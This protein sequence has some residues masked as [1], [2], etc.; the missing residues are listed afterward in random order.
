M[1]AQEVAQALREIAQLLQLKGENSFKI[2]AYDTAAE[3]FEAL[4]PDPSAPGGLLERVKAGTLGELASVGKAIDQKVSELVTTGSLG[5]L[6]KLRA[7]FPPGVLDLVRVP[8]VGPKK[9]LALIEQLD[10]GSLTDLKAACESGKVRVLKGF[11]PKSELTILEGVN[12]LQERTA[13]R[14]IHL[15][16]PVAERLLARVRA[17]PGVRAAAVAGSIRRFA[18]TTGDIDLV[19]ELEPDALPSS[20]MDALLAGPEIGGIIGRG[21]TKLSL[22]LS[23]PSGLQV[24][25][26]VLGAGTFA[27]ALHHFTGSKGHHVRLRGIARARG[28]TLSEYGLLEMSSGKPLAVADEAALYAQL[29]LPF[30]TPELREDRGEI[31]AGLANTL[32]ELLEEAQIQ[33]LIHCHTTWSDGTHSIEEVAREAARLGKRYLSITDH[34]YAGGEKG[35]TLDRLRAQADEIAAVQ[36]RTPELRILRGVEV[37]VLED[38]S[39]ALPDA[40]LESLEL[41]IASVHQR[42]GLD[43]EAQTSRIARA[44]SHPLVDIWGHPTGRILG[45]REEMPASFEKLLAK[46]AET[47]VAVECNGT[48]RRLDLSSDWLRRARVH[49]CQIAVSVDAHSTQDFANLEWAVRNARRGWVERSQVINAASAEEFLAA[50]RSK[51]SRNRFSA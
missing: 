21:E 42:H 47:G 27:T 28:L 32:P 9:A 50:R 39:L 36:E 33:G 17:A 19:C 29:G 24:D 25:L 44:L 15:T 46:A 43:E 38:G 40:A 23:Q 7:E 26:R 41:V 45:E 34:S 51:R 1:T 35:I 30:I 2:R 37:D 4:P 8:G 18:E 6:D 5:F 16:R 11:G 14:P 49:G 13:R 31:E 10:V 48:P 20:P 12:K 22:R 3:T